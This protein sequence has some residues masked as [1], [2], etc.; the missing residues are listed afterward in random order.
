MTQNTRPVID[1][2][3]RGS[4]AMAAFSFLWLATI[5]GRRGQLGL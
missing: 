5:G 3:C 2:L 4:T 1:C